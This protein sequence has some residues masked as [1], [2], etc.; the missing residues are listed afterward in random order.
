VDRLAPIVRLSEGEALVDRLVLCEPIT[1]MVPV[2]QTLLVAVP[3]ILTDGRDEWELMMELRPVREGREEAESE[4]DWE[5]DPDA[6][7]E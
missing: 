7:D 1:V 6:E 5:L 4:F 2:V 3:W